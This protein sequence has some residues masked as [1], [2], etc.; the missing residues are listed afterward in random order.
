MSQHCHNKLLRTHI[1]HAN[2]HLTKSRSAEFTAGS[3]ERFVR[4]RCVMCHKLWGHTHKYTLMQKYAYRHIRATD[5]EINR[6][7]CTRTHTQTHTHTHTHKRRYR[8]KSEWNH[9]QPEP[10]GLSS[11]CVRK[12]HAHTHTHTQTHTHATYTHARALR[13]LLAEIKLAL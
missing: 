13:D 5:E 8:V 12:S 7:K 2:K 6:T 3:P 1:R 10:T 11:P 9:S 4:Q